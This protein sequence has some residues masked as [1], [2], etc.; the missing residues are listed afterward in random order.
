MTRSSAVLLA[1]FVFLVPVCAHAQDF[2]VGVEGL[3][4][5]PVGD[6][7]GIR[8]ATDDLDAG[9][10]GRADVLYHVTRW[11]KAGVSIGV[12]VNRTDLAPATFFPGTSTTNKVRGTLLSVPIHAIVQPY[13]QGDGELGFFGEAGIGMTDFSLRVND[14]AQSGDPS[15]TDFSFI[16]GAGATYT[17]SETLALR[18]S[19][20]YLQAV[21]G[22]GKVWLEGND[23][24]AIYITLGAQFERQ[25][26][27]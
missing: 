6:D 4:S 21:T 8:S 25:G 1:A 27:E 26:G 5:L 15:Q 3:V 24:K 11:L 12:V 9:I 2:T 14:V 23:P 19:L 17:I 13:Y 16:L 20:R 7:R 18:A 22:T 10:G